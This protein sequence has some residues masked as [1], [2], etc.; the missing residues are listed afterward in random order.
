MFKT[1]M[2]KARF[3]LFLLNLFSTLPQNLHPDQYLFINPKPNRIERQTLSLFRF[4]T[5]Q[6]QWPIGFKFIS[7]SKVVV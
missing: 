7:S 6:K 5:L 1:V 4:S 3:F 2:K